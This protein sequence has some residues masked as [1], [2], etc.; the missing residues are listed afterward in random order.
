[1]S[2]VTALLAASRAGHA[3]YRTLAG[4]INDKGTISQVPNLY[5]A[6]QA[7]ASA[8]SAR[9]EAEQLDPQHTD[10]A[11]IADRRLNKGQTSES[12]I[13]FYGRYLSPREQA[14]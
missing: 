13:E 7:I 4:R 10:P 8:L 2:D 11:W 1:M 3:K 5:D 6:G 14:A 12:L 9:L